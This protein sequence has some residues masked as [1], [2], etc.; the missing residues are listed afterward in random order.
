MTDD[1]GLKYSMKGQS[2]QKPNI[3]GSTMLWKE[4]ASKAFLFIYFLIIILYVKIFF[5]FFFLGITIHPPTYTSKA[6]QYAGERWLVGR[7]HRKRTL[8]K[9]EKKSQKRKEQ[10]HKKTKGKNATKRHKKKKNKKRSISSDSSGNSSSNSDNEEA[11]SL[12]LKSLNSFFGDLSTSFA[13]WRLGKLA[14]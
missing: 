2:S 13:R 14:T 8:K 4:I 10:A 6:I 9:N 11:T 5:P 1:L 12:L 3:L 7:P